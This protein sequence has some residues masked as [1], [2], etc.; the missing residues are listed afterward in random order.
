MQAKK[1]EGGGAA[2]A[3]ISQADYNYYK[4]YFFLANKSLQYRIIF[5][6]FSMNKKEKMIMKNCS[7][8]IWNT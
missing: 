4:A 8:F 3:G 1:R 6:K 7:N 5:I 2:A